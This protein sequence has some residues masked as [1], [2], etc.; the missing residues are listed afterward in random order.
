[1]FYY[2]KMDNEN[3]RD[4]VIL[5]REDKRSGDMYIEEDSNHNL[6]IF[7]KEQVVFKPGDSITIEIAKKGKKNAKV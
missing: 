7:F 6:T 5:F 4:D 2:R 1:M 3:L